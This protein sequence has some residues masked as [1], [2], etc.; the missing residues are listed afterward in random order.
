MRVARA[1]CPD[2]TMA[3]GGGFRMVHPDGTD[4]VSG[5][6]QVQWAS[7]TGDLSGYDVHAAHPGTST[8]WRL[9]AT[10]ICVNARQK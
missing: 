6:L 9:E 7:P 8:G 5:S 4:F 10:A 3:I 2:G 1:A